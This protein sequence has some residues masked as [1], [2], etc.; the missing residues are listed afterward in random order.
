MHSVAIHYSGTI[1]MQLNNEKNLLSETKVKKK[2]S[3]T[4]TWHLILIISET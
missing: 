4:T 1:I 3:F 2:K